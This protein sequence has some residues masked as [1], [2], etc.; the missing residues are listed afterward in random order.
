MDVT[1]ILRFAL[2]DIIK[3]DIPRSIITPALGG[4]A[5]AFAKSALGGRLGFDIDLDAIPAESGLSVQELLFSETNS[6]FVLTCAPEN[7]AALEKAL[8]GFAFAKVGVT[9]EKQELTLRSANKTYTVKLD[10]I[11][12][13][14]KSTLDGI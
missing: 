10:D 4:L 14:Y 9:T 5:A 3:S 12:A 1:E 8:A 2:A 7:E 13:S 11:A 6:R